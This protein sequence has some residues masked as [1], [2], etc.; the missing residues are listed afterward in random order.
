M[1][2]I[3]EGFEQEDFEKWKR[4]FSYNGPYVREWIIPVKCRC[5]P[6]RMCYKHRMEKL[7]EIY[8]KPRT[9]V[10]IVEE[11]WGK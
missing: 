4:F 7:R 9:G 11:E 5:V 3:A 1:A 10:E 8:A 2:L 6:D